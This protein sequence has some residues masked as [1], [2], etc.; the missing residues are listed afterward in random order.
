MRERKPTT[1]CRLYIDYGECA[2]C[3]ACT[4][5]CHTLA[6][7]MDA[8]TL[9]LNR[10]LCDNCSLCVYVCPTGALTLTEAAANE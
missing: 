1:G 4:S 9:E 3:A 2:S 8:L 6:L 7:N 5:V 10:P